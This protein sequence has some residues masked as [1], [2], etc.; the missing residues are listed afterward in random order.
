MAE[1]IL[2]IF[3]VAL[4][5][6]QTMVVTLVTDYVSNQDLQHMHIGLACVPSALNSHT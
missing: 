4:G 6:V 5:R 3:V 2:R 1:A